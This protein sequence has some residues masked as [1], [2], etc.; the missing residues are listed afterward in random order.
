[1]NDTPSWLLMEVYVNKAASRITVE[2]YSTSDG[3][4]TTVSDAN[5]QNRVPAP[6]RNTMKIPLW[7]RRHQ[8]G[9]LRGRGAD[10]TV[11]RVIMRDGAQINSGEGPLTTHYQPWRAV[12]QLRPGTEGIP[13]SAPTPTP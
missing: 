8:A 5:V 3:R 2:F 4:S 11:T 9:G 10:V 1:M 13:R 12:Y 7:Q 6:S